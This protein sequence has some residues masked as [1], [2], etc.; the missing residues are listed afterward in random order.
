MGI[1]LSRLSFFQPRGMAEDLRRLQAYEER[2]GPTSTVGGSWW[3]RLKAWFTPGQ[4][5][6]LEEAEYVA[7]DDV[8]GELVPETE[9]TVF[10]DI[11]K[12][13]KGEEVKG[14]EITIKLKDEGMWRCP[15]PDCNKR[16]FETNPNCLECGCP[17]RWWL[18]LTK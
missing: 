15:V 11:T 8:A 10:D 2:V 6:L 13:L 3:A 9:T 16:N 7:L 17:S 1:I 4:V 18:L 5:R 12:E 14:R